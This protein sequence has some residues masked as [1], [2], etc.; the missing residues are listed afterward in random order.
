[1]TGPA[2]KIPSKIHVTEVLLNEIHSVREVVMVTVPSEKH[3]HH[4]QARQPLAGTEMAARATPQTFIVH[5][6]K[7]YPYDGKQ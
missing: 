5:T 7:F 6:P 2:Y 1:M 3:R 4:M